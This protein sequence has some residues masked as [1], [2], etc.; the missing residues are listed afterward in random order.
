MLA[1]KLAFSLG[2]GAALLAASQAGAH[3]K[4]MDIYTFSGGRPIGG[5]LPDGQGGVY[6]MQ[7]DTSGG[8]GAVYHLTPPGAGQ[9][10]WAGTTL[11]GFSGG[12]DGNLNGVNN[13]TDFYKIPAPF[14]NELVSDSSGALYGET[15]SGGANGF[16]TVF[17]LTPP[18]SGQTGWVE[19]VLYSFAGQA[20]GATPYGG[21]VVD[22]RGVLFGT[23]IAGGV[24]DGYGTV[25][26]LTPNAGG[27]WSHNVLHR[28]GHAAG[29]TIDGSVPFGDLVLG[30][31]GVLY[32]TTQKIAGDNRGSGVVFQ[33]TP[34][35]SGGADW[36]ETILLA[37]PNHDKLG[38]MARGLALD[39]NGI[40]YGNLGRT[41]LDT[42]AGRA[43]RCRRSVGGC[44]AVF[45]LTPP[46]SDHTW[47]F[48]TI[49]QFPDF[50]TGRYACGGV[51]P[52]PHGVLYG[53]TQSGGDQRKRGSVG[54][55]YRLTPPAA[56]AS[57]WTESEV[58]RFRPHYEGRFPSCSRLSHD[59]NDSL[60]GTTSDAEGGTGAVFEIKQ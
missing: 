10:E 15:P 17:K 41:A 38:H 52:G 11:Y 49:Y 9:T 39:A 19:T 37:A 36:S 30:A 58:Y 31:G 53:V 34:P 13:G 48:T 23:T 6:G 59:G 47:T 20:D 26:R 32:G 1:A 60:Y 35:A 12:A 7:N 22:H 57:S 29:K 5:V 18:A 43:H 56:G 42:R 3:P 27:T 33:F 14:A 40:I 16:G 4:Q 54:N 44:G 50:D 21:L 2:M 24:S 25:F 55:I 8:F 51:L 46:A 45:T 28:F